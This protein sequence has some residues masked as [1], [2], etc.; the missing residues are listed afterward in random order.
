MKI[1]QYL[2]EVEEDL[3][4][5]NI[6]INRMHEVIDQLIDIIRQYQ[7]IIKE[8]DKQWKND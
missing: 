7:K 1:D 6:S 4:S 3:R 2:E 8:Q 5:N